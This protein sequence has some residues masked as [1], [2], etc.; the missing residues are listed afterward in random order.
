MK[1]KKKR[2][3]E[4]RKEGRSEGLKQVKSRSGEI[5]KGQRALSGVFK[6]SRQ[7]EDKRGKEEKKILRRK[8][9]ESQMQER[10]SVIVKD[11]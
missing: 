4:G 7:I 9:S 2:R 5:R 1:G 8:W 3:K 10:K 11:V 6:N